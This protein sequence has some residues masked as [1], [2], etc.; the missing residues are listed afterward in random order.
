M[1]PG[2][3]TIVKL[4]CGDAKTSSADGLNLDTR[5]NQIR[6]TLSRL[7]PP[8]AAIRA[9]LQQ[10]LTAQRIGGSDLGGAAVDE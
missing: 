7:L 1:A 4:A 10:M 2:N 8:S 6:E 3:E 9:V 5:A